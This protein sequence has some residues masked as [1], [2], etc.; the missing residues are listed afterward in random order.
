MGKVVR[1][2]QLEDSFLAI[3]SKIYWKLPVTLLSKKTKLQRQQNVLSLSA[4]EQT[5]NQGIVLFIL[6]RLLGQET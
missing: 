2:E 6:Q 5:P 3:Q 1:K 4:V